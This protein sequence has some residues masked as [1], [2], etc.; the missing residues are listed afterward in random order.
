MAVRD[1]DK[2]IAP[3][4]AGLAVHVAEDGVFIGF[5]PEGAPPVLM[6][7]DAIARGEHGAFFGSPSL[8]TWVNDRRK[9]AANIAG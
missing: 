2:V 6:N 8:K 1:K 3:N 9:Q 4:A 7:L 5:F